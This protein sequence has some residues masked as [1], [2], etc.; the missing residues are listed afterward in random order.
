MLVT[1][2]SLT[3]QDDDALE[4]ARRLLDQ[5]D[6][7]FTSEDYAQ[8]VDLFLQAGEIPAVEPWMGEIYYAVASGY[9][10]LG[11]ADSAFAYLDSAFG[12]GFIDFRRVEQDPHFDRLRADHSEKFAS[13][14]LR[15]QSVKLEEIQKM[16]PLSIVE[17]DNYNGALDISKYEWEDINRPEFDTLRTQYKLRDVLGDHGGE[18]D[19][20]KRLLNW[21]A[22][23]W[24]HDGSKMAPVR[25]GLAI[26]R[27][28]DNGKR[29]CCANYA[30]VLIDCMR[31]LGYP[32]R[33]A[34]LRT[35]DAAYNMGG[36][37][38]C[39]EVWSNQF[40]KWIL[41]DAQNN[42]WWEHDSI[43]LNAYECHLLLTEGRE[44]E[45]QF[46]GQH[47]EMNYDYM[48][49]TW[50]PYF[51]RP[52][53][54][55]MGSSL[56]LVSENATP[57]LLYQGFPQ[58]HE[59]TDQYDR[60]YPSLNR[61][62][63]TLRIDS[64]DSLDIVRVQLD[65]TMPYFGRYEV[66]FDESDWAESADSLDWLLHDGLNTIEARAVSAVGVEGKPSRIV[67]RYNADAG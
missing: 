55:W 64:K 26:L 53:A 4:E 28:V 30:D 25:T 27:E 66:R 51:Y 62:S 15:L 37:H 59:I 44:D 17:Y 3:A 18:F 38:G 1:Y 33:F 35:A 54:Y 36:G 57:G 40:Q 31:S 7:A 46:V 10:L 19:R 20:M 12:S 49:S 58:K 2:L 61:T 56:Y 16:S 9:S 8:A 41:L 34:G 29:F 63:I 32:I 47:E 23:R 67:V 21:V 22:T 52:V 43:P 50:V 42:A 6:S 11:E 24:Q 5:G 45:L 65:H 14:C 39:V 48:R 13:L 60:V